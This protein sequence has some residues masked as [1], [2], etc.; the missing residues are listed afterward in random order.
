MMVI[1][2]ATIYWQ[3]QTD[4]SVPVSATGITAENAEQNAEDALMLYSFKDKPEPCCVIT[5]CSVEGHSI[6]NDYTGKT[7]VPRPSDH[8]IG[9][10]YDLPNTDRLGPKR[11]DN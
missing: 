1:Y 2:V 8:E 3:D 9:V 5:E 6:V 4:G 10:L 7:L 11:R